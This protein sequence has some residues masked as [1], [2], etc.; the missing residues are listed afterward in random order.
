MPGT[1]ALRGIL[2]L[3]LLLGSSVALSQAQTGNLYGRVTD[4]QGQGL[5]GVTVTLSGVGAPITAVTN[6]QGEYRYL[7]LSP[8]SYKLSH[9]LQGFSTVT[10]DG[11]VVNV[12]KNTEVEFAMKLSAVTAELVVTG[13]S[14]LL[15]TKK[16]TT[17][18]QISQTELAS[19][20]TARDPWVVLQSVPGVLTD[21]VNVGGNQSGQQSL[22]VAKGAVRQNSVWNV[23]GVNITDVG[24]LGSSPTYYDFDSFQE[25][26]VSTG[27]SDVTV[28]T[29][30]AALN[31]VTKRGTN[32]IHGSARIFIGDQKW[33][34]TNIPEEASAEGFAGGNRIAGTQ[35]Y[36]LEVGGPLW[37][38]RLWL[39]GSYG[40]NEIKLLT[41]INTKDNT[42]L[43]DINA[44][45]NAQISNENSATLFYLRGDKIKIGRD[46]SATRP[47]ETTR[48]QSG[49]TSVF[50]IEDSHVFSSSLFATAFFSYIDG[51][52]QLIPEGGTGPFAY[53]DT[54]NVW[55]NTYRSFVTSRPQRQVALNGSAFARTGNIG[56]E[57]KFGFGYRNAPVSSQ[58]AWPHDTYTRERVPAANGTNRSYVT[59]TRRSDTRTFNV[60]YNGYV[61]D[62][63]TVQNLTVNVGVRYDYQAG[64][65]KA[66]NVSANEQFPDLVPGVST[67][68]QN[69]PF[70]WRDLA[71]RI[72]LTYAIG[73]DNKTLARASYAR[74]ADQLGAGNIGFV[75]AAQYGYLQYYW[76]DANGDHIAQ[77]SEIE[78]NRGIFNSYNID[79]NNPGAAVSPNRIDPD[80]S[81]GK[82]DE[83][84]LGVEREVL[85]GIAVSLTGT[86]RKIKNFSWRPYYGLESNGTFHVYTS[87]D[88]VL[89]STCVAKDAFGT[90]YNVPVYKLKAGVPAKIG[91]YLTNR[92]DYSQTYKGIELQINKRFSDRWATRVAFAYNDWKQGVGDGA[93]VDPTNVLQ[94]AGSAAD[95]IRGGST[96]D[97]GIVVSNAGGG[98]GD[99]GN[100][101]INARW[102]VNVNGMYALPLG[103]NVAGNFFAREGYPAPNYVEVDPGDGLGTRNVLIQ[104]AGAQ[105]TP[106]LTELD[107][108]LDKTLKVAGLDV[109]LGID[110]FNVFNSSTA[111]QRKLNLSTTTTNAATGTKYLNALYEIQSPRIVR[112]GGRISF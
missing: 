4:E 104:A 9:Q 50:K 89:C 102:Q 13:E 33:Q 10:R 8:G 1:K 53:R 7:N 36:G 49:P 63:L 12:G 55:H 65:N 21:R 22:Y 40:R 81:A 26:Q 24:A 39:W 44:K 42:T 101:Y 57:F 56:H 84:V 88:F 60:F 82:T 18:A 112:F 87:N 92:P 61:S 80:F 34:A 16:I 66:S 51:G 2:A 94:G 78:F 43:E 38:D 62:T 68:A 106:A 85:P 79:P 37:K 52:F 110:V 91:S 23:D 108:R 75:N 107:L 73:K 41:I 5:P 47:P 32:D 6:A 93:I 99:F 86:Y 70:K 29:A 96:E 58:S 98:S 100:V 74:F 15:D 97:G 54:N 46:A 30:G 17:G 71:P 90:T 14:P 67:P 64:E 111:L 3:V 72:G 48:D 11:I 45:L 25:M 76:K 103:F 28:Q 59:I 69:A 31:M 83:F 105:R 20:P 109:T 19:I 77:R 35:D 95:A 27:G